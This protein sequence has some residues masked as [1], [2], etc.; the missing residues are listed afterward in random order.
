MSDIIFVAGP[1]QDPSAPTVYYGIGHQG[2]FTDENQ[3]RTW[4]AQGK[5]AYR[6][7]YPHRP[8]VTA[9]AATTA[10]I[11]WEVAAVC[12]STRVEYG[13]TTAYGTNVNGS[14]LTGGGVVSAN[15]SGLTTAT[16][17]HYRVQVVDA[18]G[19]SYTA[20]ATFTTS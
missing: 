11:Q 8:R 12:T 13:T 3:V 16:L 7:A 20:D 2:T 10:T 18:G 9:I 6:G 17:Y 14:P 4:R 19:T 5:A 15:L 1:V